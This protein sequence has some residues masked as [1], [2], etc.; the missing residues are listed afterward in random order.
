MV[1]EFGY[2]PAEG[3]DLWAVVGIVGQ[4]HLGVAAGGE[5]WGG[6]IT[7]LVTIVFG[8][9]FLYQD[10]AVVKAQPVMSLFW[11]GVLF[12]SLWIWWCAGFGM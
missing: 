7:F 5:A 1:G 10:D 3:R 12:L 8:F 11:G 6:E 4:C 2:G 9:G